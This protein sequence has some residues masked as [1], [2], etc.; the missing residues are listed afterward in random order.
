M[1]LSIK[2][3][4]FIFFFLITEK[5]FGLTCKG[6]PELGRLYCSDGVTPADPGPCPIRCPDGTTVTPPTPCSC[7]PP[8]TE[9]KVKTTNQRCIM[10]FVYSAWTESNRRHVC[11]KD[12]N[13]EL[14]DFVHCYEPT[15]TTHTSGNLVCCKGTAQQVAKPI[16]PR[17][18]ADNVCNRDDHSCANLFGR[19]HLCY[20]GP[21]EWIN[22]IAHFK[23]CPGGDTGENR[24]SGGN[25]RNCEC[26]NP[27]DC[28]LPFTCDGC[29]CVID[30]P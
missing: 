9:V 10:T 29:R 13:K 7:E 27:G 25:N 5:G 18:P 6:P 26:T 8:G 2:T 3:L 24:K 28:F 22:K 11:R 16:T 14:H 19:N 23:R 1:N 12:D 30:S 21:R 15:T 4:T 17:Q 20:N